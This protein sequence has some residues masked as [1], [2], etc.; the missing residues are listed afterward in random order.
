MIAVNLVQVD[1][2]LAALLLVGQLGLW[3]IYAVLVVESIASQLFGPARW[4][5]FRRC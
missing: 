5:S 4:R 2:I 3:V 1:D